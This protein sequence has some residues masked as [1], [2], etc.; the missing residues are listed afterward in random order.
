MGKWGD[1]M[2]CLCGVTR[3]LKE[4]CSSR[5]IERC[6]FWGWAGV[7]WVLWWVLGLGFIWLQ[8]C[9]CSAGGSGR[10]SGLCIG[11]Y[12]WVY[13]S[14]GLQ[15]HWGLCKFLSI[16]GSRIRFVRVHHWADAA[17]ARAALFHLSTHCIAISSKP[18]CDRQR[19][20]DTRKP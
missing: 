6:V 18:S 7:F 1:V 20:C 8:L 19:A 13:K 3:A 12:S 5:G 15:F 16:W 17:F 2:V 10:S 14:R 4:F 9:L 11:I